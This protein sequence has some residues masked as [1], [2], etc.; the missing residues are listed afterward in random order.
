VNLVTFF[1]CDFLSLEGH[2]ELSAPELVVHSRVSLTQH[3]A[4]YLFVSIVGC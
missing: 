1:Y 3:D 4:L 2:I